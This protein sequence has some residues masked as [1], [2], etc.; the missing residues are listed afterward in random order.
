MG[1][2][3]KEE[4][5]ETQGRRAPHR[6]E[7]VAETQGDKELESEE[8]GEVSSDEYA[9]S[10]ADQPAVG[11]GAGRAVSSDECTD[12]EANQHALGTG[13]GKKSAKRKKSPDS[14]RSSD[15]EG[16]VENVQARDIATLRMLAD[17]RNVR[18]TTA[19]RLAHAARAVEAQAGWPG[20]GHHYNA[21]VTALSR[22]PASPEAALG[23][24]SP[25]LAYLVRM[26]GKDQFSVL[27][28]LHRWKAPEGVRS[29]LDNCIVAFEGE[30][31]DRYGLPI[32]FG[33]SDV[34]PGWVW[35]FFYIP[36]SNSSLAMR[37]D[38]IRWES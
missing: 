2:H 10:D 20:L 16:D 33:L 17:N 5:V 12:S 18:G 37:F 34:F 30:V 35:G 4:V 13:A 28:H 26:N 24:V 27:H 32:L 25:E 36:I 11:T 8:D 14:G 15:E 19:I 31:Q 3:S 9:Y 38:A 29:R 22:N 1:P 23:P 6:L 21:W 7:E